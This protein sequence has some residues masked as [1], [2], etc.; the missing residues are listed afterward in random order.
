MQFEKAILTEYH[1][2]DETKNA[3]YGPNGSTLYQFAEKV[4]EGSK[5]PSLEYLEEWI[6]AESREIEAFV[7]ALDQK[8][9]YETLKNKSQAKQKGE[10]EDLQKVLSGKSTMKGLF[11]RKTKDEQVTTIE[12]NIAKVIYGL[13]YL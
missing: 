6:K 13:S 10:S 4:E 8:D 11:L 12:K 3:F 2:G 5:R 9:V 1:G 7:E